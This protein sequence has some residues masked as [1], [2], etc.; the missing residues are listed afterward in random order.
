M[1]FAYLSHVIIN[2]ECLSVRLFVNQNCMNDIQYD[3]VK[4]FIK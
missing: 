3:K 4:V 1:Y 2:F